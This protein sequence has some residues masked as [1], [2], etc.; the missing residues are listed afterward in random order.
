MRQLRLLL[1]I[2]V[3]TV[4]CALL[5]ASMEEVFAGVEHTGAL[6]MDIEGSVLQVS[7]STSEHRLRRWSC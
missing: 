4:Y 3:Y 2:L 1:C 7:S 5:G 6:V